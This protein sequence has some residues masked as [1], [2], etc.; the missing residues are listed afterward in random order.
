MCEIENKSVLEDLVKDPRLQ[1]RNYKIVLIEGPDVRGVDPA[2]IYN[3]KYFKLLSAK[4]FPVKVVTDTTHKTRDELLVS[5]ELLGEK[6]HFIVCHW[7]SRRGG[8]LASEAN[9]VSA[10]K[11]A[12][13]I[14]DS[15]LKQDPQA[16]VILMGDLNDDPKDVSIKKTLR[17]YKDPAR[18]V[19][20]NE[21]FNAME[22]HYKKGIGTLAYNDAWN[23]FDQMIMTPALVKCTFTDYQF[24]ASRIFN[25]PFLA[26]DYGKYKGYPLRTYA[27]G[28]Y[29]G[30]Y[31]DHFPV[32][33][34]FLREKTEKK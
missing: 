20:D 13:M 21:L 9:R 6:I 34:V 7:P 16:K 31:S 8:E 23:L 28:A 29:R 25:K 4:T 33:S 3:P 18:S 30:G 1:K 12:R 5:G 2:F 17:T 24:Y 10:G 15:L 11:T 32:F 26:E 19:T 14:F 27:G 22:S